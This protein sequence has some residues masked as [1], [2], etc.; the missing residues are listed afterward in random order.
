MIRVS[1]PLELTRVSGLVATSIRWKSE[2]SGMMENSN[3]Q[4]AVL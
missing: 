4:G 3:R 2:R 1:Y